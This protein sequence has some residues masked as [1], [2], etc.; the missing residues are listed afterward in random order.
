MNSKLLM[1]IILPVFACCQQM[2]GQEAKKLDDISH[3]LPASYQQVK[4]IPLPEGYHRVKGT[5]SLFADWL[6]QIHLKKDRRVFLYNGVLSG[7]QDFQFVVLDISVGHKDL[8]QCADAV[9][10]LRAE[11]LYSQKRYNEISFKDNSG[12]VYALHGYIDR[13]AF[14]QYLEKVFS[15]C[16]TL[17]LEK[18]L[19]VVKVFKN[20]QPGDVLIRGGSPGHAELV[21]GVGEN[22]EGKRVY[23]LAQSYMPAQD[24]HILKNPDDGGL[25]PWYVTCE[26]N[27]MINSP[28][29]TF[30][31][32]QLRRW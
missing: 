4:D 31:S 9:M 2:N 26:G 8:Q 5:D 1:T 20:I 3:P 30:T 13:K 19:H 29:W 18:Q 17:S 25:S 21:M 22:K 11:F 16:G 32:N 15:W 6:G 14:D 7:N 10:R 27:C 12:K 28:S 24:I 23:L